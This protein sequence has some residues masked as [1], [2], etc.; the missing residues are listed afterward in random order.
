MK[1]RFLLSALSLIIF[2]A[3]HHSAAQTVMNEIYSRGT[4]G[5]PDWIELYNSSESALDLTGYKIYDSAGKTGTKPKKQL[6]DGTVIPAYGFYVVL[7]ED[8]TVNASNFGL[9]SAGEWV[10][11]ENPAGQVVDSVAFTAMTETQSYGRLPDGSPNWRLLDFRSKGS[12]NSDRQPVAVVLNEIYSRGTTAAPD[13]IEIYNKLSTNTDISG[14]SIYDSGGKTGSKPKKVLPAGSVLPANGFLAIPTEG[15]GDA[16]DFGLSSSGETVWLEDGGGTVIDSVA[17]PAL[18]ESQ[19]YSRVPDSAPNWI[20]AGTITRGASN[21]TNPV[22]PVKVTVA[23]Q[24]PAVLYESS[25]LAMTAPGKIWSHNDA[26]HINELYCVSTTGQLLRT[27][28]IT[29]ATNIDWEDL[30]VDAQKRIYIADTGNNF[31]DRKDLAIF[32]IPD[33]ETS[34]SDTIAAEAIRF[35]YADQTEFPPPPQSANYDVEAM[36]WYSDSLYLFTK[37]RSSPLSGF[38]KLYQLP[39]VPGTHTAK[40]MGTC[41]MGYTIASALV[42]A[43]DIHLATG[44]LALLVKERLVVFRNYPGSRF[45]AGE[46][47]EYPFVPLP[48]QA[49]ALTFT[50]ASTLLMSEE[51]TVTTPGN[52]YEIEL[53][54]TGVT[55]TPNRAPSGFRLDQNYPNP[56]NPSTEIRFSLP[57]AGR[58]S[59]KV[60]NLLGEQVAALLDEYRNAGDY[61]VRMDAATLPS[62][63]YLY[64]ITTGS[65]SSTRKMMVIK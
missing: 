21:N 42:T 61:T 18:T 43:A 28:T 31:N 10:W 22:I 8:G 3:L 14:F 60:Y 20:L 2:M 26:G 24:L 41:Y 37:D 9:S 44:T 63:V 16:S 45:F 35:N 27:V 19:S 51:G 17:F 5:D 56:F 49:E 62:G 11:F 29:N 57:Q 53:S 38:T 40:L 34:A 59:L 54:P 1:N 39:A 7:T 65:F 36:I 64:Q 23:A 6:P 33:P 48:G 55:H 50:S 4:V 58:V 32:R 30:T 12:A 25:G 15:S 47:T 52:L 46:V 13:W